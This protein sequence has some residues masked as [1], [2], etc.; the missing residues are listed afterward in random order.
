MQKV[1]LHQEE[2]IIFILESLNNV[3]R[4]QNALYR[5]LVD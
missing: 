1:H 4:M 3:Q 2:I 5:R